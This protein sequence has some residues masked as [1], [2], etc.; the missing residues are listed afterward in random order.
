[1]GEV[2]D[3]DSEDICMKE[4]TEQSHVTGGGGGS[5]PRRMCPAKVK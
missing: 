1:M 2:V 5:V 3:E 4:E